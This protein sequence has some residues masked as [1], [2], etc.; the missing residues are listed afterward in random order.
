MEPKNEIKKILKERKKKYHE[1]AQRKGYDLITLG[2]FIGLFIFPATLNFNS[3]IFSSINFV[4]AFVLI[5]FGIKYLNS[6]NYG[7]TPYQ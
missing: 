6:K 3:V 7:E 2:V 4:I 5:F 1:A